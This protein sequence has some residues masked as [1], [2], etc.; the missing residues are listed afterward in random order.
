MVEMRN[1]CNIFVGKPE[2]KRRLRRPRRRWE[3]N[4]KMD[5]GEIGF[6]DV[7]WI[8]LAQDR[9]RW[10]ALVNTVMNLRVP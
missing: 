6:G 1:T 7:D 8:H 5:L 9:D 2:G 10:R 3:D 4:I